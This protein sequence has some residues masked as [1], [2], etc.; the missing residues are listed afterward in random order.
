[1]SET[2]SS[3]NY[4]PQTAV[5]NQSKEFKVEDNIIIDDDVIDP[6]QKNP[7][8]LVATDSGSSSESTDYDV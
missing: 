1:M 8:V 6:N 5:E 7:N 3:E 4:N 2:S